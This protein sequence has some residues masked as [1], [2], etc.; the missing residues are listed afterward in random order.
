MGPKKNA[1]SEPWWLVK[2]K[3]PLRTIRITLE[4]LVPG[5]FLLTNE[6]KTCPQSASAL[7]DTHTQKKKGG[8]SAVDVYSAKMTG[9]G[10]PARD[11]PPPT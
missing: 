11:S 5:S 7:P 9:S 10:H 3:Q 8:A 2:K 6:S 4:A 1:E